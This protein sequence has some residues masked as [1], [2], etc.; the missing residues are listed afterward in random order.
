MVL[1]KITGWALENHV[2]LSALS[3][4]RETPE[5]VYIA[6]TQHGVERSSEADS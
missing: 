1:N 4:T 3:V 6:L 2:T 5:D